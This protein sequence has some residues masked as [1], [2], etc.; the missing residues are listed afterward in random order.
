MW[1]PLWYFRY[2]GNYYRYCF[3][4]ILLATVFVL[5]VWAYWRTAMTPPGFLDEFEKPKQKYLDSFKNASE[6]INYIESDS[7]IG[8]T[9]RSNSQE[10]DEEL[11]NSLPS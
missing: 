8:S 4:I 6:Q 5:G 11:N 10:E 3:D 2:Y 7:L 1:F 9:S